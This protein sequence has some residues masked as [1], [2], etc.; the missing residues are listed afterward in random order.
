[1]AAKKLLGAGVKRRLP[2][3]PELL[4]VL[5]SKLDMACANDVVFWAICLMG[6]FGLLQI[7]NIIGPSKAGFNT[8]KHLSRSSFRELEDCMI[9]T[10]KWAKTY[11]AQERVVE[12]P[13][14]RL[15]GCVR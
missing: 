5:L 7:S 6:F 8:E 15:T 9:L 11:Q 1:M 10:L 12:V 3:G 14:P 2:I 4:M 13:I